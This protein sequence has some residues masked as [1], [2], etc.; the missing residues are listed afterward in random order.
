MKGLRLGRS[1][2]KLCGT[3]GLGRPRHTGQELL[4][5]SRLLAGKRPLHRS[6]GTAPWCPK[7]RFRGP[8]RLLVHH[9]GIL[10]SVPAC[11]LPVGVVA[12]EAWVSL[13]PRGGEA[14]QS[15]SH[16]T[17]VCCRS[18]LCPDT[19]GIRITGMRTQSRNSLA[20]Q[21]GRGRLLGGSE[22]K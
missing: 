13:A 21:V 7:A 16:Y 9:T 18:L 19:P 4:S 17:P 12:T 22:A 14:D 3:N 6:L 8:R 15:H 11:T 2:S 5:W 10:V 1:K 20:L